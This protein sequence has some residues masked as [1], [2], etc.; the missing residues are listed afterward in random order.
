MTTAT[1][2]ERVQLAEFAF[3]RLSEAEL[4]GHIVSAS[5]SGEGGWV[6]PVNVDVCRRARKDP[7]ARA[8]VAGATLIVPDGMP[9]IWA[10]RLR[11]RPFTERVTGSSLIY[12]LSEAAARHERTIYLLGGAPGVPEAAAGALAR[13]Y[14]GL[15]VAGAYSPRFGFDASPAGIAEVRERLSRAMPDIVYVGLGF[16]KQERLTAQLATTLPHAWFICCGAAIPFAAGTLTRAPSWMQR[17]GLEWTHR[18]LSEPRRL[19]RRYLLED[20]PYAFGLLLT[21]AAARITR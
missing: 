16:P 21:S 3:D 4:I 15:K 7:A 20:L 11:G 2:L 1:S 12:S 9:L 6:A 13:R 10:A 5:R 14:P 19:F 8:L 17:T 18:L